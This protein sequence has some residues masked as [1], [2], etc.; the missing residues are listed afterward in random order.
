LQAG[1]AHLSIAVGEAE[2]DN[3]VTDVDVRVEATSVQDESVHIAAVATPDGPFYDVDLELDR[4]GP[5]IMM[6]QVEGPLGSGQT[7]FETTV[8]S[9]AAFDWRLAGGAAF[10]LAVG[11]LTWAGA[12]R[13]QTKGEQ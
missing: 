5:W 10:V 4:T 8:E 3:L 6:V 12:R 13:R 9:G 2:S 11:G 1:E 7:S